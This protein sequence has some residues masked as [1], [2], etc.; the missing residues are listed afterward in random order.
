MVE[1]GMPGHDK[2]WHGM[3]WPWWQPHMGMLLAHSSWHGMP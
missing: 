3:A 2:A 1:H